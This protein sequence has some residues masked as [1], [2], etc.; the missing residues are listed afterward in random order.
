MLSFK[1]YQV[2][3]GKVRYER[4]KIKNLG[5]HTSPISSYAILTP[6]QKHNPAGIEYNSVA[7][8]GRPF[9]HSQTN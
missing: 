2:K 1:K 7:R 4:Q 8:I 5:P 3:I 6:A 9:H